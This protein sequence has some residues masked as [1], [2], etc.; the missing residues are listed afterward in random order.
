MARQLRPL[1]ALPE[2]PEINM[3][4]HTVTYNYLILS[5]RGSDILS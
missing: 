4:T 2:D 5:L 3:R 1:V